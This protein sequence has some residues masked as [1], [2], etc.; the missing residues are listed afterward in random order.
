MDDAV[1]VL[2]LDPEFLALAGTGAGQTVAFLE[3]VFGVYRKFQICLAVGQRGSELLNEAG[4]IAITLQDAADQPI[5]EP[6]QQTPLWQQ[7]KIMALFN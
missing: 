5:F 2:G 1:N 6:L 4:A 3:H 7:T